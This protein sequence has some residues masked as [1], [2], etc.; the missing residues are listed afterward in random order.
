MTRYAIGAAREAAI[1]G[2][3]GSSK[4]ARD[5]LDRLPKLRA[6]PEQY[7]FLRRA[8]YNALAQQP[9]AREFDLR[10]EEADSGVASWREVLEQHPQERLK[11][12]ARA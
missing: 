10:L 12:V 3:C 4:S 11:G 9:T 8:W 2:I 6:D 1:G 7:G 5:W